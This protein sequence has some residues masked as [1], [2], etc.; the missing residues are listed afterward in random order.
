M[1]FHRRQVALIVMALSVLGL[2]GWIWVTHLRAKRAVTNYKKHLVAT[3]ERL[4]IDELIPDPLPTEQNGVGI[5]LKATSLLNAPT[6]LLDTNPP[7]AMRMVAP[8]KAMVGW[9]EPNIQ[10]PDEP[11]STNSWEE[12]DA[13]IADLSEALDLLHQLVAKPGMDFQLDYHQ[14][15][16]LL[17]PNLSQTKKATQRLSAAALCALHRGDST[18]AVEHVRAM[19]ALSKATANE[20]L[21]ISQLVR[22]AIAAI[23]VSANWELLQSPDVSDQ[24][25]AALQ[26]NWT[27][28]E[29]VEAIEHALDMERAMGQ[30]TLAGLRNSSAEFNKFASSYVWGGG[31]GSSSPDGWVEEVEQFVRDVWDKTKLKSKETAWRVSW[32]YH[33]ELR[34]LKGLQA[35]LEASRA[36]RTDGCFIDALR[37]Q[38]S[39]LIELGIRSDHDDDPTLP[40][41]LDFRSL[42]SQGVLSLNRVLVRAMSMEASRQMVITAIALK[43]YQLRHGEYP[44][45]LSGLTPEFLAAIPRDPVDGQ[46]LRYRRTSASSFLLYSMGEDAKDDGGDPRSAR[47]DAK[48]VS[49]RAGRDWVWPQPATAEEIQAYFESQAKEHPKTVQAFPTTVLSSK[50][51]EFLERYG[52]AGSNAPIARTS[53]PGTN[54]S[55]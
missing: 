9:K 42:L 3:G 45:D 53:D 52:L 44:E 2:G 47:A 55:R 33:D 23:T 7:S 49:W 8:G 36:V 12:A 28:L 29:F 26:R 10:V 20:R 13:T 17:L 6:T 46:A 39:R 38:E 11:W 30:M 1:K 37:L 25:L 5:F 51:Q 31:P 48:S 40:G 21:I 43:R 4:A 50:Q 34:T 14:G 15:F 27:E 19:L 24:Q 22:I 54:V 35:L 41:E 18:S 16:S 32:S